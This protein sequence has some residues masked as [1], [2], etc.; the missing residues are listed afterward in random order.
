MIHHIINIRKIWAQR[1]YITLGYKGDVGK[2]FKNKI[3]NL[4]INLVDTGSDTL[5]LVE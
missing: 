4:N 2:Y 5:N 1:F 3:Q